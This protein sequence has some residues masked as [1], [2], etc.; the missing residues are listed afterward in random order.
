MTLIKFEPL[1][2]LES[3]HDRIQRYFDDF[4]NFGFSFTDSFNPRIDISED[5]Q[6]LNIVA[7]IPGIKKDNLKITLQDNILTIEGEKKKEDEVKEKNYYRS[8]RVFGSFKRCFTLPSE[9]D[10]EKV[11]A[12]FEDGILKINLKKLEPKPKNEKVIELK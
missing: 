9:V 6:S 10:S 1:R 12:K 2:E 11:D 7:E 5:E 8:E 4:S 3:M